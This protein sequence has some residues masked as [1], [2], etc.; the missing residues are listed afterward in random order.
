MTDREARARVEAVTFEPLAVPLREPFVIATGQMTVTRAVWVHARVSDGRG[1]AATGWGEAAAL[2]PVTWEDEADLMALISAAAPALAG[3][4]LDLEA[5][6]EL[7]HRLDAL[8]PSSQ[9]ARAAVESAILDGWAR[10]CGWS[11]ARLLTHLLEAPPSATTGTTNTATT[12]PAGGETATMITDV[13]L[14]IAPPEHMAELAAGYRLAGFVAFKVKVGRSWRADLRAL[15]AVAAAV[16]DARFRLD[17]NAGFTVADATSLLH[18][19]LDAG[20]TVECFEQPCA[21][22]DWQ[23]MAR[24][25]D[26]SPTVPIVADESF[27]SG[28]DLERILGMR[29]AHAVNLKLVK[30]GGPLAAL[31]LGRRARQGGLGVMA[32]AMVETR[33][34]LL[35]MG[36]VVA[37]LGGVDFVDLDTAFLLAEEPFTGGWSI[38]GPRLTLLGGPGL[39]LRRARA[40]G[41]PDTPQR[42]RR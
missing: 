2:P 1:H 5:P 31:D 38:D 15:R 19:V 36:H 26:Q 9:V 10:L 27:R 8:F 23:G 17:A 22:D 13:T 35:A 32:G 14:P 30:L 3:I 7:T 41:T 33:L 6:A 42:S 12:D 29:A 25:T 18:A 40:L 34:G 21:R 4:S 20:M 11:V 37:A 16:P 39:G 28:V 24:L